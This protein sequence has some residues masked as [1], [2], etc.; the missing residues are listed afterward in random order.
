MKK[1][2]LFDL[3]DA[4]YPARSVADDMYNDLFSLLKQ[5]VSSDVFEN[6]RED[7]LTTPFQHVAD[8]YAL[9]KELKDAGMNICLNMDYDGPMKTFDDFDLAKDNAAEKAK[10]Q[11]SAMSR[12]AR[13]QFAKGTASRNLVG[14]SGINLAKAFPKNHN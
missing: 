8:C 6:I 14:T 13:K 9:E 2:F 10:C 11:S 5:Y 12:R 4:V 3:D 7:I 1:A